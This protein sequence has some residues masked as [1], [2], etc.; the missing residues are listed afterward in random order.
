MPAPTI[1]PLPTPPSRSTDPTNFAI[2]ADA[3]V[4]ALPEFVTDAN[5]QASYLDGVAS[6]VD[7]DAA[8]AA[9]SA[10]AAL[11][12][13]NN[14]EAAADA[15]AATADAALWVSGTTYAI[16]D[17]VF[18]PINYQTYRRKTNGAGTTDPSLDS[19]NWQL[20]TFSA[21]TPLVVTG[22][23]TSGAEL[24]LPED[25]DNGSN[26]IALKAPNSIPANVT[27]TLPAADGTNG[28][29]LATD[30][31]G[32]FGF[33]TPGATN[34]QEF[35]T[36]GTWTKPFGAQFV[37][38]EAW[39]GGGGGA[40]GRR[41][42]SDGSTYNGGGTGG[43]GGAYVRQVFKASDLPSTVA[44]TVGAAGLGG[45]AITSDNTNGANGTSGG[46]ST[47][48]SLITA[49][50]GANGVFT[51]STGGTGTG[52]LGGQGGHSIPG[53]ILPGFNTSTS[54]LSTPA[55][56]GPM[57]YR[58]SER[59]NVN[60]PSAGYAGGSGGGVGSAR[61][62]YAGGGSLLGGAGGGAGGGSTINGTA[63]VSAAG[64]SDYL[65]NGG[66]GAA[67][68]GF[69]ANGG[70]G[71][72]RQGGGG[73]GTGFGITT[74]CYDDCVQYSTADSKFYA[75]MKS[76]NRFME[77]NSTAVPIYSPPPSKTFTGTGTPT[78][79][80]ILNNIHFI[81]TST[82]LWSSS[83]MVTWTQRYVGNVK[84]IAFGGGR[85]VICGTNFFAWSTDYITWNNVTA[86]TDA[87]LRVRH[88]GTRFVTHAEQNVWISTDGATWTSNPK[89]SSIFLM[90]DVLS[91]GTRIVCK[92]YNN[93]GGIRFG[94]IYYSDNFGAT[95]TY[96]ASTGDR[97]D[98]YQD[99]AEF[100]QGKFCFI[101]NGPCL[102]YSTNGTS[103][104]REDATV[105]IRDGGDV[106]QVFT[107]GIAFNP[108][109]TAVVITKGQGNYGPS[110]NEYY[111]ATPDYWIE[112]TSLAW[113]TN[114]GG[115]G[116]NGGFPAGGGGGGGATLN[117]NNSGAGG[118][119]GAG[120]VRVYSW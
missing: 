49:R 115:T 76:G 96:G 25:T 8:A 94:N 91:N 112:T 47:F 100:F 24:R 95:W 69:G 31:A 3:F 1:T 73:G 111:P 93:D 15:A 114:P 107:N 37:M 46:T 64:G 35:T 72:A 30:G 77:F 88:D 89:P 44:V 86:Y 75:L 42:A 61:D 53:T 109:N 19:T 7:A 117:G 10:A 118:A 56:F 39:G 92:G 98:Y 21:A 20:L 9:A 80:R 17:N 45:A 52:A 110:R 68:G 38:V 27:F 13:E 6:A 11:V 66:G 51:T 108:S 70:T 28:Q 82:G 16:G 65:E 36:S 83:D 23:S 33:T 57:L 81:C 43:G 84:F 62:A 79:Y 26:Y 29:V 14:A 12:S 101:G 2:E 58:S 22:N 63:K 102:G 106:G 113:A 85:Y 67:G 120:L 48:G 55:S 78:C 87:F 60:V 41:G 18:S 104:V 90:T 105:N 116:G 50:G 99:R 97:Q 103:F 34:M 71:L 59:F 74:Y 4:A 119:G 5:A 32:N 54:D 40:S